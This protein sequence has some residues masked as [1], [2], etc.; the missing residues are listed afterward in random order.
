[1]I[2]YPTF[3]EKPCTGVDYIET[4]FEPGFWDG[5]KVTINRKLPANTAI[6]LKFE[7]EAYVTV[8]K[9]V[10]RLTTLRDNVF[11]I[12]ILNNTDNVS[13]RVKGQI[14]FFPPY[15][16]SVKIKN[17]ENCKEPK[18]GYFENYPAGA[19]HRPAAHCVT[20]NGEPVLPEFLGVV[21]GKYSLI[22]GDV[23]PQEREVYDVIVHEEYTHKMLKNDIALLKLKTRIE[24]ST[25]IQPAC[26]W[27]DKAAEM[28][29]ANEKIIGTVTGWGFDQTDTLST[30]LTETAMPIVPDLDCIMTNHVLYAP[31]LKG[32]KRFCAGFH[33]GTS[34]CN[35]D[36]GGGFMVY[37][38]YV[39][40]SR[41]EV[42]PLVAGAYYVRGIVS[43][44][45][46]K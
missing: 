35:G 20:S 24:F 10:A 44:S 34:A 22:G 3:T 39:N 25:Y 29:P 23:A 32:K 43:L 16:I 28:L 31:F 40:V 33:N 26:L 14:I 30:T 2:S 17:V 6:K 41:V 11:K 18:L 46:A 38:P 13:F 9:S 21:L 5:Y 15:L 1:M 19:E 27:F 42:H 7:S 37:I 45:P 8:D 36:S 4:S 12:T